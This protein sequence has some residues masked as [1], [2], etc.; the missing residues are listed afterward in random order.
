MYTHT[1]R[2]TSA[3]LKSVITEKSTIFDSWLLHSHAFQ[4]TFN[5]GG[6]QRWERE[7]D[8]EIKDSVRVYEGKNFPS[9]T[10]DLR[11]EQIQC[12]SRLQV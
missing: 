9:E 12:R 5:D 3:T 8:F 2:D 10:E 1:H 4:E 6:E 7:T 11:W